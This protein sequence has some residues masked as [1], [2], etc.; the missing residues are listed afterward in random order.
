ML[1]RLVAFD[2][3]IMEL[4]RN[5][6]LGISP[7]C[8][9][10]RFEFDLAFAM[11]LVLAPLRYFT[12]FVQQRE[13]VTL[14][15]V[16][17]LIDELVTQLA[18]NAFNQAL[19]GRSDEVVE[20]MNAFQAALVT[21]IKTRYAPMFNSPSLARA[22]AF[23]LPGRRYRDF[24][25]F[26]NQD[27]DAIVQRLKDRIVADALELFPAENGRDRERVAARAPRALDDLREDL[28]SLGPAVDPLQW[29]PLNADARVLLPVAKLYLAAM[30]SSAEDERNFSS[31]GITLDKLRSRLEIDNF[32]REHRIRRYLTAG[33]DAQSQ[34]GRDLR[35]QRAERLLQEF[36]ARFGAVGQ[37]NPP[38]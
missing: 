25:N 20:A 29:L 16:P 22:A 15:H 31:A 6:A 10:T 38:G 27:E 17:H 23:F 36:T 1:E 30:A 33:S 19:F 8:I 13:A 32:R 21:S 11:T 2:P 18:P 34:A 7:E 4:Y 5:A 12:K 28:D 14:A 9:L 24:A 37:A 3:E 35:A 26:P